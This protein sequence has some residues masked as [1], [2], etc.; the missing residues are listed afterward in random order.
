LL[1]C[2][3]ISTGHVD[4]GSSGHQAFCSLVAYKQNYLTMRIWTVRCECEVFLVMM[5]STVY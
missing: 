3:H 5:T 4:L 1:G 2:R